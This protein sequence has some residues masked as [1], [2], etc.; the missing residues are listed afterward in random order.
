M[1]RH[2]W[3]KLEITCVRN[4]LFFNLSN[5]KP[6]ITLPKKENKGI[7][8]NNVNKR[9]DLLYPGKHQLDIYSTEDTYSVNMQLLLEENL[10]VIENKQMLPEKTIA[11]A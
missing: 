3:V 6:S 5:S 11:Y 9:L 2:P 7:G 4:Q 1:L 10:P 8:L